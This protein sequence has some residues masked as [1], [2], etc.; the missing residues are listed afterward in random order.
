MGESYLLSHC[1]QVLAN[2]KP[3][4]LFRIAGKSREYII[5]LLKEWNKR[6]NKFDIYFRQ[7]AKNDK[8]SLIFVYRK[9][10]LQAYLAEDQI[11][12]FLKSLDYEVESLDKCLSCVIKKLSLGYFP[13]EIGCFLGYP[14]EDV[15]GFIANKGQNYLCC[16]YWKVY[17]QKE[18]KEKLFALYDKT[19]KAYMDTY[20]KGQ[21]ID[22]LVIV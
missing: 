4:N 14:Y 22:K 13:H 2:I 16:G 9:D 11:K 18:E 1:T 3:A 21:D 20:I 5:D 8:G 15:E 19:R 17:S 6:F 7:L 12:I 10:K